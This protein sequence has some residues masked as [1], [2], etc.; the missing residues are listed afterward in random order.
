[1]NILHVLSQFE[2]TGAEAYAVTLIDEQ[3][4]EG[5]LATVVSDT[6]TLPTRAPYIQ[7]PIGRRSYLQ[8]T[9]NIFALARLIRKRSIDVVHAHSR[10]ASWVSW[11]ATRLTRTA[12]I[13]TVHGRQHVHTSSKSFNI[14]G[15]SIIVV[16]SALKDHLVE[17]LG[18]PARYIDVIPNCIAFEPWERARKT[19]PKASVA[20]KGDTLILF[21]GRLTGPK[22]DIVRLLLRQVLPL[23]LEKQKVSFRAIGGMIT[24]NDIP[25]MA[26]SLNEAYGETIAELRG[27]QSEVASEIRH[28]TVVIGSGRVVPESLVLGKPVLAFGETNYIGPVTPRTFLHAAATNFGDTGVHSPVDIKAVVDDLTQLLTHPPADAEL[29]EISRLSRQRFDARTVTE[30][31]IAVYRKAVGDA[32]APRSIPVLMY[33]R[34][35][36]ESAGQPKHGIWVSQNTFARQLESLRRRGFHAITFR[37]YDLFLQ[38]EK[39]L[40]RRP[41][42][43]TF[44]DGY[45]DNFTIALP[46][47]QK[48]G[49]AA[50][51]YAVTDTDRRS[52]F[53][54]AEETRAPLLTSGQLLE[55][56]RA[57]IEIGSHTITHPRLT[58]VDVDA[59]RDELVRSR[60]YLEDILGSE[61]LS[62]AYP[63]GAV[64]AAVKQLVAEAG[65]KYAAA[66]DTGPTALHEDFLEIRRTQ[67]F[68]WTGMTGFW[69]KTLPLYQRYK[70]MKA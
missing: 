6:L 45:V 51:I 15:R 14:Y 47:L 23:I 28:A 16:S 33:H 53:W 37:D 24:P 40:P 30:S 9:R 13:S 64:N 19:P 43:L 48:Y 34:V 2:V 5:H 18:I 1:M 11:F 70:Q 12:F 4:R 65:Y 66:A 22:G 8:R 21:V 38:G 25:P 27:F 63:Y 20:S 39:P 49:F 3:L 46:L 10:A 60:K 67:V 29:A 42:I 68:P 26:A 59:A 44:D 17:D 56:H 35:L 58:S 54:D 57:G 36:P 69:K 55:L 32:C 7:I 31:V 50:V 41:I 62:F 52:N 61:V